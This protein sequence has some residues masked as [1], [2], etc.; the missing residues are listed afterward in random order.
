MTSVDVG[1]YPLGSE[2]NAAA[3]APTGCGFYLR[4]CC[5]HSNPW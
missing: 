4:A 2:G 3:K 5:R 1:I